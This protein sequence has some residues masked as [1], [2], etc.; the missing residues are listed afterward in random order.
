MAFEILSDTQ[1]GSSSIVC[2]SSSRRVFALL[3]A[4]RFKTMCLLFVPGL[5]SPCTSKLFLNVKHLFH[6]DLHIL[7]QKSL[8]AVSTDKFHWFYTA[9]D[10]W[11][12][13]VERSEMGKERCKTGRGKDHNCSVWRHFLFDCCWSRTWQLLKSNQDGGRRKAK[14]LIVPQCINVSGSLKTKKVPCL[15]F[16]AESDRISLC[17]NNYSNCL[18]AELIL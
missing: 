15:L 3:V 17:A 2:V 14:S 6:L 8:F 10:E 18:T 1:A 12:H 16:S 9:A 7:F 11:N 4:Y 5:P 13:K